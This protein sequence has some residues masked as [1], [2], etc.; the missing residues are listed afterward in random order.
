MKI[1]SSAAELKQYVNSLRQQKKTIGFV[2]TMGA[3]HAGHLSLVQTSKKT[4]DAT[5]MSIFVNPTQFGP[6]E[7]LEKYP[8]P[9]EKDTHLARESGVDLLFLPTFET[10]YPA[11]PTVFVDETSLT[12]V[13]C[14]PF[15]P[16]H[17]RGVCTVVN[18][19]LQLVQPDELF[20]GQKDGQQLRVVEEM[21]KQLLIPVDVISV[22]TFREPNGLAM[23]S[24]NQ[25]LSEE[26]RNKASI[27]FQALSLGKKMYEDGENRSQLI[28]ESVIEK[29]NQEKEFRIQYVDLLDW[30]SFVKKDLITTKSILAVA[31]FFSQTRLI[32]NIILE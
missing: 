16:G 4:N 25:Y 29:L 13:L 22:P 23:S 7:D 18:K 26:G 17:F 3:L 10:L 12:N 1:T 14:G 8:R 32:D 30:D 15:R 27:I 5:I 21:V 24:R 28:I 31:G 6:Q 20:L 19:F 2:P 11:Y 9:I